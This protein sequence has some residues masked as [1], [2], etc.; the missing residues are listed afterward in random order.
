MTALFDDA[1]LISSY[2]REQAI[3]DGVLVDANRGDLAEVTQQHYKYPVA[4]TAAVFSLMERAVNNKRW[5][6]DYRGIWHDILWMSKRG[7]IARPD[8]STVVFKVIIRGAARQSVWTLKAVCGPGDD[9]SPVV[10]IML[11]GED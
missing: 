7:A 8:P 5:C 11:Y 1:D 2:S 3:A 4:L 6:N 9:L 10:T